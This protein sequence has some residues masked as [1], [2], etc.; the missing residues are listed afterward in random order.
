MQI[1]L[2]IGHVLVHTT[3]KRSLSLEVTPRN[4]ASAVQLSRK[5]NRRVSVGYFLHAKFDLSS[6]TLFDLSAI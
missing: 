4:D 3:V 5:H 1:T 6:D 2:D